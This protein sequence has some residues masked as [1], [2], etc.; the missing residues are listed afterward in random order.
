MCLMLRADFF[1]HGFQ[2]FQMSCGIT[3]SKRMI[4]DEMKAASQQGAECGEVVHYSRSG[5]FDAG[6][7]LFQRHPQC[8]VFRMAVEEHFAFG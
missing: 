7:D 4:G 8:R 2:G 5:G 6:V 1:G 3:I